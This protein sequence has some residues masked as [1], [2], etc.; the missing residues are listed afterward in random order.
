LELVPGYHEVSFMLENY[1]VVEETVEILE[2]TETQLDT[3][4]VICTS[5][6]KNSE[7]GHFTISP[8]PIKDYAV[9]NLDLQSNGFVEVCVCNTNGFCLK[10]WQFQNQQPGQK[11]FALDLKDLPVGVYFCRVQIGNE[12]ITKKIIKIQ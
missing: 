12:R 7:S 10:N 11:E 4:M 3:M 1:C 2:G 6:E 8:N 5:V 9:L